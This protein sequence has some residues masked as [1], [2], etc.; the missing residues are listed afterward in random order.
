MPN[1]TTNQA[2]ASAEHVPT[3][4]EWA[5]GAARLQALTEVFYRKVKADPLLQPVFAHMDAHHPTYVANFSARSSE[6]RRTIRAKEAA[7]RTWCG[8]I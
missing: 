5:G 4:Y 7:T 8:S 3:L 6:D 1:E 2:G